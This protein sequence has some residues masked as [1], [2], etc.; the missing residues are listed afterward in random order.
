[1]LKCI[2]FHTWAI[3][4]KKLSVL[5][6]CWTHRDLWNRDFIIHGGKNL[7]RKM[8]YAS[9]WADPW[10]LCSFL[11]RG[12]PLCWQRTGGGW[13]SSWHRS[14]NLCQWDRHMFRRSSGRSLSLANRL[15][16]SIGFKNRRPTPPTKIQKSKYHL[17]YWR[18]RWR[19]RSGFGC[20]TCGSYRY[21]GDWNRRIS[22]SQTRRR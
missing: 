15:Y 9:S 22:R 17:Q 3:L 12:R 6:D 1:M 5:A 19:R 7:A 13:L 10:N 14:S 2:P 20:R 8:L 21:W 11:H 18:V 4:Q 16:G